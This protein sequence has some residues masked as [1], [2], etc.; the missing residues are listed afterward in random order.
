MNESNKFPPNIQEI[1]RYLNPDENTVYAYGDT[2]YNPSGKVIPEDTLFHESIHAQQQKVYTTPAI[3]WTKYL[4]DKD[5]RKD[6]EVEA[7]ARQYLWLKPYIPAR[8]Y[9][10]AIEEFSEILAN[11]MYNLNITKYE[12]RTLISLKSKE[13]ATF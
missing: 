3:W 12:A 10:A 9:Q 13:Y 11:P 1:K 4:L 8:G 5:F 7:Y 6:Q 2:L